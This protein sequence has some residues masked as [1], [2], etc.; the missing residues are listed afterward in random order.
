MNKITLLLLAVLSG[1][2]AM[3]QSSKEV[4]W[5]TSAKKINDKTYEVHMTATVGGD[6]HIYA[7]HPG[8]DGPIPTTFKFAKNPLITPSGTVKEVGKAVKKFESA[9]GFNVV[10]YEKTVDFVV[11]VNVKGSAK[12][13]LTATVEYM[14]C[15][16]HQCLPP[17]DTDLNIKIG[18]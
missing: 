17:S 14:V 7:Q 10:Y 13:S 2:V 1:S 16:D 9:W 4:T 3:A 5:A 11:N 6:Y 12:S 18:G 15:D 8:G